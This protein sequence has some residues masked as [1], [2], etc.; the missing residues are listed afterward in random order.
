MWVGIVWVP[1]LV[2]DGVEAAERAARR[3][4]DTRVEQFYDAGHHAGKA[5]AAG[6]GGPGEIAWDIYLFYPAGS[7]WQ[8][9]PPL[10]EVWMHQLS[11]S[12][13]PAA[14][15][16][17]GPDLTEHLHTTMDRLTRRGGDGESIRTHSGVLTVEQIHR[18]MY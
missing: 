16:R 12:W 15:R 7:L 6:L 5:I 8:N 10:P 14:Y 3:F 4:N 2:E 13:A 18:F 1:M 9:A 11:A 17:C